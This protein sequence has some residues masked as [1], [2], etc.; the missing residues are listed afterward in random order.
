[1][2]EKPL[3]SYP[4]SIHRAH[5]VI[6]AL[7]DAFDELRELYEYEFSGLK[8][9]NTED[10]ELFGLSPQEGVV[11]DKLARDK[12]VTVARLM[13]ATG[14]GE[15]MANRPEDLVRVVIYKLRHK[16]TRY[17]GSILGQRC[18]GYSVQNLELARENAR[19]GITFS[20]YKPDIRRRPSNAPEER[21]VEAM[22]ILRDSGPLIAREIVARMKT[23]WAVTDNTKYLQ[24]RL[25]LRKKETE[26]VVSSSYLIVNGSR[27]YVWQLCN[28]VA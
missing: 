25:W 18:V 8:A 6:T 19:N 15:S 13:K 14:K 24:L 23:E 5:A 16:L 2:I 9:T 17:G 11:L 20:G 22:Q 21:W 28:T 27:A 4:P 7:S 10:M 26:G 3:V 12:W 1:M